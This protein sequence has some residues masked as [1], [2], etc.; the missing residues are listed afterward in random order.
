VIGRVL[1]MHQVGIRRLLERRQAA[2]GLALFRL[3]QIGRILGPIVAHLAVKGLDQGRIFD[4]GGC[5][6]TLV[7]I[8]TILFLLLLLLLLIALDKGGKFARPL[9]LS[10]LAL[11]ETLRF[12]RN[13][14]Q[15]LLQST[16]VLFDAP[17][18]LATF[19][20]I[21]L[22]AVRDCKLSMLPMP[23]ASATRASGPIP[24]SAPS[25]AVVF[26]AN[27]ASWSSGFSLDHTH[28]SIHSLI[29]HIDEASRNRASLLGVK[30][31]T[32]ARVSSYALRASHHAAR[33]LSFF[34]QTP[35]R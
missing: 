14:V 26:I 21:D 22:L 23:A 6:S 5:S 7:L 11:D 30:A 2:D 19:D 35:T 28:R 17:V 9:D 15:L 18:Q 1:D 10:T 29:V 32:V 25:I 33:S 4:R 16:L 27:R 24:I 3:G 13:R 31:Q 34:P 20:Q 8:V 12:A